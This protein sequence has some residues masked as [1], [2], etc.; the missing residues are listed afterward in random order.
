[1]VLITIGW[2]RFLK[3]EIN[4]TRC[5]SYSRNK[6]AIVGITIPGIKNR[7]PEALFIL[8]IA[9][10]GIGLLLWEEIFQQRGFLPEKQIWREIKKNARGLPWVK[11]LRRE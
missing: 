4:Y 1:L 3:G 9:I 10:P 2:G 5:N 7:F 11:A 6:S 8:G